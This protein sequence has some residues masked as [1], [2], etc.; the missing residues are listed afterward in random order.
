MAVGDVVSALSGDNAALTFQPA[1][2]VEV[3][4]KSIIAS[5]SSS[6]L[7][8]TD[9]TNDSMNFRSDI[10]PNPHF[11]TNTLFLEIP[12]QGAGSRSAYTGIQTK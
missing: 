4:I 6:S 11:L 3:C 9:G 2:G 5:F 1:A 12:A 8:L 10:Y 7:H